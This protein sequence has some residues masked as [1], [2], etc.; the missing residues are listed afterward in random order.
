MRRAITTLALLLLGACASPDRQLLTL[1]E[2]RL[3]FAPEVAWAKFQKNLPVY[4]PIREAAVLS[5][6]EEKSTRD[7]FAAQMQA[8][9]NI[10]AKLITDWK[11]GSPLPGHPAL[12]LKTQ[13]RPSIDSIDLAQRDAIARGAKPPDQAR[14]DQLAA[15]LLEP[16]GKTNARI[17]SLD[18][19]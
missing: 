13:I 4:D 3:A 10:Q 11:N 6:I 7:F 16:V 18:S 2:Q 5:G 8:S 19:R 12:D 17:W 1:V 14:I 15:E 9:R